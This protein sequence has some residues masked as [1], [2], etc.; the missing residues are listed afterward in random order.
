MAGEHGKGFAVVAEEVRRLAERTGAASKQ[1][2]ALVQGIQA[3]TAEAVAAMAAGTAEVDQGALVAETAGQA[4][5]RIDA[6]AGEL[7]GLIEAISQAAGEQAAVAAGL[8]RA[9]GEIAAVTAG[10]T[11]GTAQ[12]AARVAGL[13][14]LASGLRDSVA[15]FHLP[16]DQ[17]EPPAAPDWT[18][19]AAPANRTRAAEYAGA[20]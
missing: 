12:A 19:A 6:T 2:G 15:T 9:M 5:A 3:E 14:Q 10:T 4:L 17:A 11:A 8:A 18:G 1:I 16:A 13:A 20:R 7:A